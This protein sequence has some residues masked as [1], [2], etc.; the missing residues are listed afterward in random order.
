[1][2]HVSI[3]TQNIALID[4]LEYEKKVVFRLRHK[5]NDKIMRNLFIVAIIIMVNVS[6]FSQTKIGFKVS[7]SGYGITALRYENNKI[8]VYGDI[9]TDSK[10]TLV[11][12]HVG[13][14]YDWNKM[15]QP[16]VAAGLS[17]NGKPSLNMSTGMFVGG[18]KNRVNFLQGFDY[19]LREGLSIHVGLSIE[20]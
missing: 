6:V 3:S 15:V 2:C 19:D 9:S 5:L 1:M 13:V 18:R 11:T 16:Y 12:T 7:T 8:G 4:T 20:L 10:M 17:T 14:V